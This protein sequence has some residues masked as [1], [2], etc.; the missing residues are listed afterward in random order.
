LPLVLIYTLVSCSFLSDEVRVAIHY[1]LLLLFVAPLLLNVYRSGILGQGGFKLYCIYFAWASITIIYSVAPLFSLA[2]LGA[3][4]LGFT[5]IMA[6]VVNVR[7]VDEVKRLLF[8]F[9]I[10][11]LLIIFLTALSGLML[12]HSLTWSN[13]AEGFD[14]DYVVKLH[15][16][17]ISIQ[18]IERFR[19]LF[20]NPNEVGG[21]MLITVGPAL[22]SWRWASRSQKALLGLTILAAIFFAVKA[23]SR[24]PLA[25]LALGCGLYVLWRNGLRGAAWLAA[26]TLV[27]VI[28]LSLGKGLSTYVG[29]G[30]IG[31][32][33]GRTDVWAFAIQSIREH[34]ILGFGYDVNGAILNN[35]YFPIWY[36]P[37][38]LG[39]HSS[40][41][42]GYLALV[43][44]V[45]GPAAALWLFIALRPWFFIFHQPGDPWNL[46]SIA[47]LVVVPLLVLNVTEVTLTDFT[48]TTA[49]LFGLVWA[50]GERYRL[51]RI[52]EVETARRVESEALSPA[53]GAL[54]LLP[55]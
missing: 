35:R 10:G 22:V 50:L 27:G 55:T 18:G 4:C 17:G 1:G 43:V 36:G 2:R 19:G 45:G 16:A 46:K 54:L 3:S 20:G 52:A 29:R 28:G 39:P 11:C 33:T 34:P 15:A 24:S 6:C 51:S 23:D 48:S 49:L 31:T 25:A 37:W 30:D 40:L 21:F 41:H 8:H 38:D 13:P 7:D 32:L 5:A 47:L 53:A 14:P 12:P 26:L 42:D 9:L 44:G